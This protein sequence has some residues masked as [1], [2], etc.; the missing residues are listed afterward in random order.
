MASR[1]TF[2]DSDLAIA[3]LGLVAEVFEAPS[4]ALLAE[5]IPTGVDLALD[6][7]CGP[8]HTTRLLARTCRPRRTVGVDASPRYV[9]AAAAV[10]AAGEGTDVEFVV[11]DVT[12]TPLPGAPADAIYLRL[13]LAHLPDPLGLVSRWRTQLQPGG[14]L[15]VDEI[16]Q[17][18][19]PSGVLRDYE[20][21]VVA[22]VAA[23]GGLMAAGPV[24]AP[25]GGR[26]VELDV[27][28][29]TAARMFAINLTVWRDDAVARGLATSAQLDRV[30]AGL[31]D[32]ERTGRDRPVHWSLRQL[33]LG[34]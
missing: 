6:L 30:A 7:G 29:S 17:M 26:L 12:A 8:G 27:D 5:A 15:V 14:V 10:T 23:E 9:E 4:R 20:D 19:T 24:L 33:V 21:V 3:R 18:E 2:G 1:Y 25:L 32:L 11:H 34:P 28:S 22:L 16:E 31:A 13:L